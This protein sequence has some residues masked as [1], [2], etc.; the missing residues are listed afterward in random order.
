MPM[1]QGVDGKRPIHYIQMIEW[2]YTGIVLSIRTLLNP[3]TNFCH[4]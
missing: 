2:W 4:R 1:E 3:S